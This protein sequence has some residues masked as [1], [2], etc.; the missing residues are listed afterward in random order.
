MAHRKKVA[1]PVQVLEVAPKEAPVKVSPL[2]ALDGEGLQEMINLN[3]AYG[4]LLKQ[5][6]QY[7]AAIFMLKIRREQIKTGELKLPVMIHITKNVSYAESDKEKV[8][9]HFDEEIKGL[10]LARQGITGTMEY[11]RDA[12]VESVIRVSK[13]LGDKVKQCDIKKVQGIRPGSK[14]VQEK[15]KDALEKELDQLVA[16]DKE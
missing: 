10:Q 4:G 5:Q 3:N 8:L 9:K 13:M 14:E 16:K 1:K 7:D 2:S 12:F 15:E 11:R 6:A